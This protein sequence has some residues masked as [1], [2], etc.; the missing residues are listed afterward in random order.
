VKKIFGVGFVALVLVASAC[1][2]GVS[3]TQTYN[4]SVDQASPEDKKFQFSAYYPGTVTVAPGDSVVFTNAST[5][6]PHTITFG[7]EDD[8]SNSP[9]PVTQQ[10][11]ENPAVFAPCFLENDPTNELVECENQEL[12]DYNGEGY[13]NSGVLVPATAPEGAKEVTVNISDEIDEGT[14]SFVCILH[15]FMAGNIEVAADDDRISP[16]EVT[17]AGEESAEAALTASEEIEDPEA[18]RDGD[19]VTVA[20]GFGDRI[21]SVNRFAPA[22]L[23]VEPGTTVQWVA[24]NPYEPHTV[25][26]ESPFEGPT[27]EGALAPGGVESG[28]DY[29]GGF[30]SSGIL[31]PE[32]GPFPSEPFELTFN[33]P[34]TYE[35]VCVLHPGQIGTVEVSED[36]G[37]SGTSATSSPGATS[38]P[39]ATSSP[40]AMTS[41]S[42]SPD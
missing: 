8:R 12:P 7:I 18:E 16:D 13:W 10:G 29:D 38:S 19:T 22:S 9:P 5:E 42:P 4:V 39:R 23:D 24:Q 6:A 14:Y 3:G 41:P 35:Y 2:Q 25:T 11:S 26:F 37:G 32:G 30:S 17:E 27:D 15:S 40:D 20:A 1:S 31:G 21:V 33:E 34:G 36:G 28:E